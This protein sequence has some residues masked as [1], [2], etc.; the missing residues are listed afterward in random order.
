MPLTH[1]Q[2]CD[3]AV[4]WLRRPF[5]S[6][7]HAC[8]VAASEC[9]ISGSG[10]GEVPD[11][12]GFRFSGHRDGTVVVEVKTS[13]SD[14]LADLRKPHRRGA[15][16]G[17]WRYYM[18]PEGL[19]RLEELPDRWGLVEVNDRGHIRQVRGAAALVDRYSREIDAQIDTWRFESDR[20]AEL[21][22]LTRLM[23]RVGDHEA[24]N[25]RL[26]KINNENSRLLRN[27]QVLRE[28][29]RTL[30]TKR[31]TLGLGAEAAGLP[32]PVMP[33][34]AHSAA[35]DDL[36]LEMCDRDAMVGVD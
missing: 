26:A 24:L 30:R 29:I 33:E 31:L 9:R 36:F 34:E 8:A 20:T 11:A 13:R 16:L 15:G 35:G 3:V 2:L 27:D 18:A 10:R 17:S 21:S 25:R 19:V 23:A 14:F 32:L 1:R 4:K 28:E 5:G 7:G 12:I 22:L 6:R